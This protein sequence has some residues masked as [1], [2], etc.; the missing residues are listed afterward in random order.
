MAANTTKLDDMV[1]ELTREIT[2]KRQEAQAAWARFDALR[3]EL[4]SADVDV[5]DTS[6]PEFQKAEEAHK[7]Y[8]LATDAITKKESDR[9]KL[10]ALTTAGGRAIEDE[11]TKKQAMDER[12]GAETTSWGQRVV[13]LDSYRRAV[14]GGVFD[15]FRNSE[16][17]FGEMADRAELH[18]LVTGVSKTSAGAFVTPDR[19][20]MVPFAYAPLFIT[21]LITVSTT[22]SDLV[23]Y[24]R[25]TAFTN[26]A[27][28]VA[29]ATKDGPVS[30][31]AP[32]VTAVEAGVKPQSAI[33]FAI[34]QEM[35]KTIAHWIPITRRALSDS[36]QMRSYIDGRLRYGLQI[37]LQTQIIQGDGAGENFRGLLNTPGVQSQSKSSDSMVDALH[38]AITKIRLGYHEPTAVGIH[39]NDWEAIRLAKNTNGDYYYGPPALAGTQ[40]VWGMPVTVQAAFPAGNPL[41]GDFR[42]AELWLRDGIQVLASDSHV[43]FFARNIVALLAEM[44][45]AFGVAVPAAFCEV[46][47]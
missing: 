25:E 4:N 28:P 6:T 11:A 30:A 17:R 1:Q 35:V 40:T 23:E 15:S 10:Y 18:A 47:A 34:V 44:R 7:A 36:A 33:E 24:V 26:N 2:A 29:E 42:Q 8:S 5:S 32:V 3:A 41:V 38:K 22:D 19:R 12:Y 16:V 31:S 45:A 27:A 13:E 46:V 37:A 14:Q 20:S 21:D 9:D 43:D 39:P